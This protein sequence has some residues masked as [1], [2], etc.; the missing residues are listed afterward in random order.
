MTVYHLRVE[1]LSRP[2]GIDEHQ[3]VF[4]WQV[5]TDCPNWKQGC[6]RITAADTLEKLKKEEN[7]LWDSGLVES[8]RMSGIRYE[9][10]KLYSDQ[11]VY[12]KVAV[13]QAGKTETAEESS[14]FTTGLFEK[15]DWRG[16]WIG[17]TEDGVNSVYRHAFTLQN[18]KVKRASLF[19]CGLGHYEMEMNGMPVSDRLLE[20]GWTDYRE[21][22]L[23]SAYDVTELLQTGKNAMAVT[24]GNGMFNVPKEGYVYFERSYGKMR[25]LCQMNIE[26][27]DGTKQQVVT[28]KSWRKAASPLTFSGIYGGEDYDARLEQTGCSLPEFAENE[29]WK[30]VTVVEAPNGKLRMQKIPPVVVKEEY[31]PVKVEETAPGIYLYDLGKNF[32]GWVKIRLKA[33]KGTAGETVTL[34]P[35][36]ILTEEKTPDQRV[37]GKGYHWQYTMKDSEQPQEY[38]PHFSYT[39]FR[40]IQL[41][42]AVPAALANEH[43]E[44]PIVES[45][46]GQFLYPDVEEA[47]GFSC[48]VPLFNQIHAI[49]TQAMKSNMKSILTDCPHREKLG[50]MEQTHLIGPGLLYNYDIQNL[51]EKIEQDIMDAQHD[52]GMIPSICPQYVVFGYH[53]GFNDSPEWGSAGILV[54]WYY[55]KRYGDDSIFRRYYPVM[56]HYVEYLF[57]RTHHYVLHHGLGD[58]LDIG[59]MTPYSQN[60]PVPVIATCMFYHDLTVMKE[61]ACILG[62]HEDKKQYTEW[63]QKVY[64][65]YN[66]QFLDDQ[67]NRYANG[68]QAAQAMSLVVG[69]VPPERVEKVLEQLI[70]DIGKRGWAVTAGDVGHP[71]LVAAL[72]RYGRSDVMYQMT[73]DTEKPG[74]GYQVKCGATTLTEEWDGPNPKQPHGSQNHFML[75]AVEEWFY[76]GLAGLC[77]L[78]TT[79]SYA[80]TEV[81]PHFVKDCAEVTAWSRHPYGKIFIHYRYDGHTAEVDLIVPPNLTVLFVNDF[82]EKKTKLGSGIHHLTLTDTRE[83]K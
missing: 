53:E 77:S 50:W 11:T 22:V 26:Y 32:S 40:Y 29:D 63:R 72:T 17:E 61:V 79:S 42:G 23:Y 76:A 5:Q 28:D 9:G 36:E 55:Y 8:D 83:K 67:T 31:Q 10:E 54:P 66:L 24:L 49:V 70:K 80:E 81:H 25:L 51:Y 3:P 56:K 6:Y 75:G 64:E 82:D 13:R 14:V 58:W 18:K 52:N 65:E 4:S 47:G 59:P 20:P 7:L 30:P 57:S 33:M 1:N 44:R 12:W 21:T 34:R 37:T 19:V 35:G 68:S 62:L 43:E 46:V 27:T 60:T 73:I 71:Y 48:S 39:G 41:E 15:E 2:Y 69:L 38:R 45:L 74:Y 78:R 16:S